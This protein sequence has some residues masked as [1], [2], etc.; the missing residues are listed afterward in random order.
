MRD[1]L[2]T[3]FAVNDALSNVCGDKQLTASV[4]CLS[5]LPRGKLRLMV[6]AAASRLIVP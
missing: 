3:R 1:S 6:N 2:E 5:M 4:C